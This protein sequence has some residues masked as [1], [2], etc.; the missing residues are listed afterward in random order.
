MRNTIIKVENISKLYRLGEVG[1]G[2]IS[3]DLNRWWAKIRGNEDPF[4]KIGRENIRNQAG[5]GNYVWS[6]KDINFEV[7]EGEVMGIIGKNGAGKSTLLKILSRITSPTTGEIK[8]K[9]RIAS[10]LEVGT[11]FHPDLT[12]KEN[13]YLN[14][15]IMGMN[16]VEIK[17]KMEEIVDFSGVSAY[18]DTPVKRYSSGMM[19]RLGFAVAAHLEPEILIIDEV[20]AVGDAEFQKK[21]IGKMKDV[22]G[23]GRTVLFVSHN[24][25]AINS[26]CTRCIHLKNGYIS[27]IG[28]SNEIV[29]KYLSAENAS[30]T[31]KQ[32]AQDQPGDDVV[33]LLAVKLIDSNNDK[34]DCVYMHQKFGIEF[35]YEILKSGYDPHPNIQVA[36]TKGELAFISVRESY[37]KPDKIGR[38]KS[39]VWIPENLLNNGTYTI[40]IALDN[41]A[42]HITHCE[43]KEALVFDVIEDLNKRKYNFTRHLAGV[44][45]PD[46][47][48]EQ[49]YL[50][51]INIH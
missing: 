6:L 24:M 32:W 38:H 4:L 13:I 17:R 34:I 37:N 9:G 35:D 16:K 8:M 22:A 51:N 47:Q 40:R 3:H 46:L 30:L 36:T 20:L 31:E 43:A 19:V 14:G 10:L 11:G 2:T 27:S 42:P 29:N 7:T 48:W 5:E 18:V 28:D 41:L 21:C 33:K 1:T 23:H 15:A 44:F 39:R 26:L 12:G 49:Y 25:T 50:D 45:R